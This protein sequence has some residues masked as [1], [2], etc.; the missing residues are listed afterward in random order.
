MTTRQL[1][2]LR[3]LVHQDISDTVEQLDIALLRIVP[4]S[5]DE[6]PGHGTGGLTSHSGV[7]RSLAVLAST[8]HD[9]IGSAGLCAEVVLVDGV[10][11][12]GF[13]EQT[14]GGAGYAAKV[15]SGV[16]RNDSQQALAGLFG[17]VWFFEDALCGV[18]IWKIEGGPGVARVEDSCESYARLKRLYPEKLLVQRADAASS[19]ILT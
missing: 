14:H 15:A 12:R 11:P 5:C 1:R 2:F 3:I 17:E 13:L 18:N 4:Q 6:S 10:A 9:D 8:P 19:P 16:A 7:C